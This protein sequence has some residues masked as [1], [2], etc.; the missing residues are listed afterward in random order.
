MSQARSTFTKNLNLVQ[1]VLSCLGVINAN[2]LIKVTSFS[3]SFFNLLLIVILSYKINNIHLTRQKILQYCYDLTFLIGNVNKT[4]I[5]SIFGNEGIQYD[6]SYIFGIV[7][8][9]L[10]KNNTEESQ[11]NTTSL[12]K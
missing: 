11:V 3:K 1:D 7:M 12:I 5:Y 9:K 10:H 4:N 8:S 6:I 2:L